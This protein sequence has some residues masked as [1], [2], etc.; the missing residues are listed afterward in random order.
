VTDRQ[1]GQTTVR[2]HTANCFTNGRPKILLQLS[3]KDCLSCDSSHC[4]TKEGQILFVYVVS[5]CDLCC[6]SCMYVVFHLH[7]FCYSKL[8]FLKVSI[9]GSVSTW[10]FIGGGGWWRFRG[11]LAG[12]NT[13][14]CVYFTFV[15]HTCALDQVPSSCAICALCCLVVLLLP[16]GQVFMCLILSLLHIPMCHWW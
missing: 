5:V 11:L 3:P 2:Q 13:P 4:S 12:N 1:T 7:C 14:L 8:K 9:E 15:W 16:Q 10:K 6:D